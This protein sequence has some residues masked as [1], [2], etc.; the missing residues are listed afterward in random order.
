MEH[1]TKYM[2]KGGDTVQCK[3]KFGKRP[4]ERIEIY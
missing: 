2:G 1:F 4:N 3:P